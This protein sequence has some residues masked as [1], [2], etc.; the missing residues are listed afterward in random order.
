M[1]KRKLAGDN[2]NHNRASLGGRA[3]EKPAAN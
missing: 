1:I 2:S 3:L